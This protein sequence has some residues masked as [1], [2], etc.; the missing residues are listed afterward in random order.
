MARI[1]R[2]R[3]LSQALMR[4]PRRAESTDRVTLTK[5]EF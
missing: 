1:A 5:L 4:I 2:Q 3:H